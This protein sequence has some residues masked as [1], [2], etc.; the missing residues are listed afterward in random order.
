M[1]N[2]LQFRSIGFEV[3]SPWGSAE[4]KMR[5]TSVQAP[6]GSDMSSNSLRRHDPW[7]AAGAGGR[8]RRLRLRPARRQLVDQQHRLPRRPRGVIEHRHLLDRA[9]HPRL[10]RRDRHGSHRAGA[11]A[12][13]HP[14][15]RRPH[16]RQ[17][18]LRRSATIVGHERARAEHACDWGD[19]NSAGRSGPRSTGATSCWRRRSSPTPTR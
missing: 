5:T 17:L 1:G 10:P 8:R 11:D 9:P 2:L 7:P 12:G 13:Q 18:P 19:P 6:P 4:I 16:L 3:T 14:P 15:P